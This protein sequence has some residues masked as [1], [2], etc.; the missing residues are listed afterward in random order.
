MPCEVM[1][2]L[3][4]L[5]F[6]SKGGGA[7]GDVFGCKGSERGLAPL[8]GCL[9][10]PVHARSV[11]WWSPQSDEYRRQPYLWKLPLATPVARDCCC[12]CHMARVAFART[13]WAR[14]A[15]VSAMG[16]SDRRPAAACMVAASRQIECSATVVPCLGVAPSSQRGGRPHTGPERHYCRMRAHARPTTGRALATSPVP[17]PT[18]PHHHLPPSSAASL[19]SALTPPPSRDLNMINF[20]EN[21]R[22]SAGM[23]QDPPPSRLPCPRGPLKH[24]L[25]PSGAR[26]AAADHLQQSH[27]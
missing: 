27:L 19:S 5:R 7:A 15:G 4:G 26:H 6:T 8:A 13:G 21:S 24:V 22:R 11:F 23:S 1:C 9:S 14:A 3:R 20:K 2:W 25:D 16:G 12:L 18:P 17:A 10:T